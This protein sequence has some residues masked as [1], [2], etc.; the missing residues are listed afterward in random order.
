MRRIISVLLLFFIL[1]NITGCDAVKKKFTRK[2]KETVKMPH[3]YQVQKYQKKPSPELYKMHYS[4]WASWQAEL[5]QVLGRSHKKDQQCIEQIISNLNDMENV[6]VPEKGAALKKHTDRLMAVKD[7]IDREEL[8][9]LNRDYLMRTLE[10]EGR[11]IRREF[12][13]SKVRGSLRKSFDD[14]PQAAK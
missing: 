8:G 13:Y 1:L 11:Y 14:E 7:A 4:Y 5:E 3:I 9:Q 6:L 12:C 10:R 2:K